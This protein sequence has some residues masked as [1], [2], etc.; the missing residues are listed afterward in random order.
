MTF[1]G[2][3]VSGSLG[4]HSPKRHDLT[5]HQVYAIKG[6]WPKASQSAKVAHKIL[7]NYFKAQPD[8]HQ[9]YPKF[10]DVELETL[11]D[12]PAFQEHAYKIYDF[13]DAA[14]RYSKPGPKKGECKPLQKMSADYAKKG[15][16]DRAKFSAFREPFLDALNVQKETREAWNHYLDNVYAL[17]FSHFPEPHKH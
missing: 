5:E 1:S 17:L 3:M 2:V 10:K 11:K 8:A 4:D 13:F 9:G 12:Q 16:M 15:L 6:S 14:I 7:Y